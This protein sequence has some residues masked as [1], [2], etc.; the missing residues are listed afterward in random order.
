M[1]NHES[2]MTLYAGRIIDLNALR[3]RDVKIDDIAHALACTN[4]YN[5]HTIVPYSVA[6]HCVR[7]TMPGLPGNQIENLM[8]DAAEAYVGDIIRSQKSSLF[9]ERGEGK[10]VISFTEKEARI[11][12]VIKEGLGLPIRM[13]SPETKKAD[14][15][16]AITEFR[17]LFPPNV[18]GHFKALYYGDVEPLPDIIRPWG[19]V[20]AEYAFLS[21][22]RKLTNG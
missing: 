14:R 5:G 12:E 9:F 21:M 8:H 15:I 16:M 4:R 11:F 6:E 13:D 1:K 18:Y 20:S 7:M 2:E 3:P 17:D 19:W 10:S 22:Y